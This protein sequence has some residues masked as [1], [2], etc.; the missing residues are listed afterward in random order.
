ML[1]MPVTGGEHL[2][3]LTQFRETFEARALDIAIIDL[4]R[5][6]GITPWRKIAAL[7][8][9]F[10]MKVCGHVVPEVHAHLLSAV[11]NGHIVEFMPRSTPILNDMPVP[12]NGVLKAPDGPG[13]GFTLKDDAV[14][15]FGVA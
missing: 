2:Y 7:A 3:Q 6:G 14:E 4:A 11:P 8:E 10:H 5:A 13:L 1:E 9:A 15:K 12:E